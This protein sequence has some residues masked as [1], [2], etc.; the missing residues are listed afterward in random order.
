MTKGKS[1]A[2]QFYPGDWV[3]DTSMLSMEARGAWID[4]LCAMWRSKTRGMLTISLV[5]YRRLLRTTEER[6]LSVIVEL[7]EMGI[8]DCRVDG[9]NV[10]NS[11]DVTNC[12]GDVTLINRRMYNEEKER[13]SSRLRVAKHRATHKRN[14]NVTPLSSVFSLQSSFDL[15]KDKSPGGDV[16]QKKPVPKADDYLPEIVDRCRRIQKLPKKPGRPFNPFQWVQEQVNNRGHPGA[17]NET[18]AALIDYWAT[19]KTPYGYANNIFKT[20]NGNWHEKEAIR[21]HEEIK[22]RIQELLSAPQI[23]DLVAGIGL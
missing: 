10:T 9:Q 21:D 23:R 19:T 7:V 22:A 12:N 16:S 15:S 8:C 6:A 1:P 17:I 2:F 4:L 20:K 18:L 13:N 5:G 14:A 3:Q 11:A